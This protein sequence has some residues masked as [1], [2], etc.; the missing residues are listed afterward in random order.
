MDIDQLCRAVISPAEL[1]KLPRYVSQVNPKV[2][3]LRRIIWTYHFCRAHHK[4]GV[5]VELEDGSISNIGHVCGGDKDKF[6]TKFHDEM[7]KLSESRR[8]EEMMPLLLNR[9]ELQSIEQVAHT[10]YT[11]GKKWISRMQAFAKLH[12]EINAEVARR[13]RM[14]VSMSVTEIVMRGEKEIEDVVA[15]GL[16]RTAEAARYKEVQKG[17]LKGTTVFALTDTSVASLWRRAD[18]LLAAD[19]QVLDISALHKLY[20][21]AHN[22]PN[23]AREV[24]RQCDAGKEFFAPSNLALMV[25]LSKTQGG[26]TALPKLTVEMLD[27]Q[28]APKPVQTQTSTIFTKP[29]NKKQRDHFRRAERQRSGR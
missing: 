1:R 12:P 14:G 10:A 20:A 27:T 8:R 22:L 18:T 25:Q 6:S 9:V 15:S 19:P 3:G 23:Q 24:L 28:C 13:H 26:N 2:L 5:I 17:V 16:F 11:E 7:Q 21:E 4:E 29:L